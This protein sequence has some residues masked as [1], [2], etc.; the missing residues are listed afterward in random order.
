MAVQI[1]AVVAVV[2]AMLAVIVALR[3]SSFTVTRKASMSAPPQTVF[4]LVNDF[5]RWTEWSPWEHRDPNLQR[6]FEGPS[7]GKGAHYKWIGNKQVGEGMMTITESNPGELIRIRL[8]F[9]KPFK[10]TNTTEFTFKPEGAG[11]AVTWTMTGQNK[12]IGKAMTIFMNMDKMIGGDF[13]K[14]LAEMKSV[15]E[16]AATH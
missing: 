9:I 8:E 5:H 13:E 3:P 12:F 1:L 2:F 7:S 4:A 16:K 15:A 14:G 6:T 11:T 10:S